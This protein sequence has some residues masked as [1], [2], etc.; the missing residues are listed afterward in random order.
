MLQNNGD[1]ISRRVGCSIDVVR[2]ASRSLKADDIATKASIS[3]DPFD[4]VNDPEV[5]VVI[6][7][8]CE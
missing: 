4:V 8:I 1:E 5:D 2:I 7:T 3:N 6:E